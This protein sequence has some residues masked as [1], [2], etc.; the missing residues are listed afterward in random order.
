MKNIKIRIAIYILTFVISAVLTYVF[1]ISDFSY[2]EEKSSMTAAGLPVVYMLTEEGI[3]Y[4]YLY[5]HVSEINQA[6]YHSVVT[7]IAT[8]REF[9]FA[10]KPYGNAVSGISYEINTISGD[11]LIERNALS[12]YKISDGI[13]KHSFKLKNLLNENEEYMIKITVSLESYGDVDYYSRLVLMDDANVSKKILYVKNFS[14]NT[15]SDE[16]LNEVAPKLETDSTGDNTNLGRVNIHSKLA[17]VGFGKLV[18]AL[19]SDVR[20]QLDEIDGN[21]AS[22]T[23]NYRMETTDE[24]GTFEYDV[25]EFYRIN[26]VDDKVTYVNSFERFMNQIFDPSH[27]ISAS[28]NIYLG[29][30]ENDYVNM[31][32]S[33]SGNITCFVR[34]QNLW[35]YNASKNR[36]TKVFSFE[37]TGTDNY[38]ECNTNH[39]IQILNVYSNGDIL[40]TVYGYMNRGPHEGRNGIAIYR[41]TSENNTTEELAFIPSSDVYNV[42]AEDA[43]KLVYLNENNILYFYRNMSIYYLNCETKECMLVD[44]NVV[45]TSC[46]MSEQGI[47]MYQTGDSENDCTEIKLLNLE[48]GITEKISCSSGHRI[49]NFGYIDSNIVYGVADEGLIREYPD[50]SNI[51]PMSNVYIV[52]SDLE[53]VRNY[54]GEGFYVTDVEIYDAKIILKRVTL[55]EN[56]NFI[57]GY[58]DQM[59]SSAGISGEQAQAVVSS[60][61]DRQKELYIKPIMYELNKPSSYNARYVFSSET[62]VEIGNSGTAQ[63]YYY[64]YAYGELNLVRTELSECIKAAESMAGVVVDNRGNTIW[65]RYKDK[66]SYIKI[67]DDLLEASENTLCAATSLLLKLMD[68]DSN[69]SVDYE[70]GKNVFEILESK[71]GYVYDLKGCTTEQVEFFINEGHPVIAKTGNDTYVLVYG[72]DSRQVYVVDFIQ[73]NKTTYIISE[74]DNLLSNNGNIIIAAK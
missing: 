46:I 36:F 64:T 24:T 70:S 59:L 55:D 48:T 20:V 35:S 66:E 65:T 34:N 40:F 68:A 4:N 15:M 11:M 72:Y 73:G 44:G 33:S 45:P 2:K 69:I 9:T 28:G 52:N 25:K 57:P 74:F 8:D 14:Q 27:G 47:F 50:G 29:I 56:N 17:Q 32:T 18:P 7:P 58:D 12:D 37:D 51:F 61:T 42:I 22:I 13:I 30:S 38:R 67:S 21:I 26:Q 49:R 23:L 16:T 60:T 19:T 41:Y 54:N 53:M 71:L 1:C 62:V 39:E 3:D 5:G 10:I 63:V 31:Q 43:D 6:E